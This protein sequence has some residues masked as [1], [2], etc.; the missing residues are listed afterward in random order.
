MR[1]EAPKRG[2]LDVTRFEA[3]LFDMDGVVTDT[4]R[5]HAAAWK[6]A[7]DEFLKSRSPGAW[8]PFDSDADYR[9]YV[10]GKP[11]LDGVI[12]FLA[13]RGI[14]LPLGTP[15]DSGI[16]TI[17]G[18]GNRKDS[19]LMRLLESR[20][21]AVFPS[22][23]EFINN[24][25]AKGLKTGI[26]SASKHAESFLRSAGVLALFDAKVDGVDAESLSLPGKPAPATL[27]ELASR[28]GVPPTRCAV[29]EDAIAGVQA[30]RAGGFGLVIGVNR[31]KQRG[32]LAG[33]GAD[34]EVADLS[35][36][37]ISAPRT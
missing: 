16:D 24:L 36:V 3:V 17:W 7:F 30:G 21:V 19:V 31:S 20:G 29:V 2:T 8:E 15:S 33:A 25:R 12:S 23:I 14:A 26:F 27:L 22:T 35:E 9:R 10:D 18:L 6:E 28:L 13:S 11:R 5:L 34:V 37:E 1:T 4:A 32:V